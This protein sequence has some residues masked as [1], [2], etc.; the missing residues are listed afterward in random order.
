M[1]TLPTPTPGVAL[2]VALYARYSS[3]LQNPLSV[4]DQLL[5]CREH[6][7]IRGWQIVGTY[8]DPAI[9]GAS[10][11]DR[12]GIQALMRAAERRE[13]DTVLTEALDRLSRSQAD[14][15]SLYAQL[16]FHGIGIITLSENEVSEVHIGLK[17]AMN[18]LYIKDLA[19]KI[20][21]GQRGRVLEGKAGAGGLSY[22]YEVAKPRDDDGEIIR[23]ERRIKHDEAEIVRRIFREY[24]AG[25]SPLQ[26]AK[27]LNDERIP[28]P[29][30]R[31]WIVSGIRGKERTGV[32]ILNNPLYIGKLVWNRHTYPKNPATGRRVARVRPKEQWVISAVPEL[33][34]VD[35]ELWEMVKTRQAEQSAKFAEQLA[36]VHEARDRVTALNATH[37]PRSLLSKLLICGHCGGPYAKR[38]QDRYGCTH[39]GAGG[40]CSNGRTIPR[41]ELE[42]RVLASLRGPLMEP[43]AVAEAMRG[44]AEEIRRLNRE[45]NAAFNSAGET[46]ADVQKNIKRIVQAIENGTLSPTLVD[47]LNELE[48][49][50]K[51]LEATLADGPPLEIR[52]PSVE[53]FHERIE[54]LSQTLA[55]ED[56]RTEAAIT[57]RQLIDRIVITPES[58]WSGPYKLEVCGDLSAI[59]DYMT[60][61]GRLLRELSVSGGSGTRTP[62]DRQLMTIAA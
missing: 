55:S 48:T 34:I 18:A 12:P 22:G 43:K 36:H 51:Q 28:G 21:R 45:R 42:A 13:F 47:R 40:S 46:L 20:R 59:L 2:R 60:P 44:Y 5:A 4:D 39:H 32:G 9:S 16:Q 53:L 25:V 6:A 8:H 35:D 14:M 26:I 38:G 10:M 27:H 17:G 19:Q 37:R 33:R 62:R 58:R 23:G 24:G 11:L 1:S 61:D 3:D 7:A 52:A 54:R 30:G 49:R 50:R 29:R 56:T 15:A 57:L 41:E 31:E